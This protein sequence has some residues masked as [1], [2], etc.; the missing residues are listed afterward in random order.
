[1]GDELLLNGKTII[2][3]PKEVQEACNAL[4]AY[5]AIQ[6]WNPDQESHL[7]KAHQILMRLESTLMAKEQLFR[8]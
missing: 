3:P 2:A 8:I 6:D 4:K 5:E 7:F 1:M